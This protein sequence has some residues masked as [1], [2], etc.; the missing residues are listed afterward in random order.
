MTQATQQ[1]ELIRAD[2]LKYVGRGGANNG[3]AEIAWAVTDDGKAPLPAGFGR[4]HE[5]QGE[6]KTLDYDEVL[7][8]VEGVF[9]IKLEGGRSIEGRAGDLIVIPRGTTVTYFGSNAKL[10]FVVTPRQ[11]AGR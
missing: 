6:P 10:F 8:V 11:T 3:I 4:W 5:A 7:L 2:S 1:V 9:G